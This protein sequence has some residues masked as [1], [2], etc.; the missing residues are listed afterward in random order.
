MGILDISK[1]IVELE[2]NEI[3]YSNT[4]LLIATSLKYGIIDIIIHMTGTCNKYIPKD[5]IDIHS[6]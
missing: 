5:V 1:I 6:I 2:T 3:Q 4:T